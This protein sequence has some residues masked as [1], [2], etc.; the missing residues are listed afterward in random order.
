VADQEDIEVSD[1]LKSMRTL[2]EEAARHGKR[3]SALQAD[4]KLRDV[5]AE[6]LSSTI[7]PLVVEL[8]EAQLNHAAFLEDWMG[9]LEEEI[10]EGGSDGDEGPDISLEEVSVLEFNNARYREFVLGTKN[11]PEVPE[12]M[13][14][15][16][17]ELEVK[18]NEGEKI[19]AKLRSYLES[20]DADE[21]EDGDGDV[22]D[23]AGE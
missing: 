8:G 15:A 11:A 1:E 23:E 14:Q 9:A 12:H 20:E 16:M 7:F 17:L 22:S 5:M 4:G 6:E 13:L 10:A 3:I 2:T 19:V 18:L 21:E